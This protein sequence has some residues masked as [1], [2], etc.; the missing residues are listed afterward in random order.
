MENEAVIEK[1]P[2]PVTLDSCA[3]GRRN[4]ATFWCDAFS[5]R[6]YYAS[7]LFKI[8]AEAD[9]NLASIF[10]DC[11]QQIR[12]GN[13]KAAVMRDDEIAAGK[14][15]HFLERID[16]IEP[17]LRTKGKP[18]SPV[19]APVVKIEPVPQAQPKFVAP[20]TFGHS[21]YADAINIEMQKHRQ[22]TAENQASPR[23]EES[24]LDL[25]KRMTNQ[26]VSQ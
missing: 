24:L 13:C 10:A 25:A 2:E 6:P 4:A 23:K 8:K 14:P 18:V 1:Q 7:C 16:P 17:T 22:R 19:Q 3:N 15:I 9:D 11:G 5:I 12:R 21:T 26:G 20:S